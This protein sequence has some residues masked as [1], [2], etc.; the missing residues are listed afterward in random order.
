MGHLLLHSSDEPRSGTREEDE[1]NR[2]AADF[3]IPPGVVHAYLRLHPSLDDILRLKTALKVSAMAMLRAAHHHGKLSE[4][5]YHTHLTTLS[6]RGF[7]TDEP[8]STLQYER[9]R[10]FDYV[11]SPKGAP[12]SLASPTKHSCR[13]RTCTPS[14]SAPNPTRSRAV[15]LPPATLP[16]QHFAWCDELH[17]E[18]CARY[19]SFK[20]LSKR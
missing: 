11:L 12:A 4:R 2:F 19:R 9:S 8:G 10:V 17:N 16:A 15:P 20:T 5:E 14:C 3:L 13:H 18:P 6:A 1:A 7:R